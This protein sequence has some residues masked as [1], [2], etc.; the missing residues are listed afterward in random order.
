MTAFILAVIVNS[1]TTG[2]VSVR[3]YSHPEPLPWHEG[4]LASPECIKEQSYSPGHHVCRELP[5][6]FWW[7]A[8]SQP[9]EVKPPK[10]TS[11]REAVEGML[12]NAQAL[13]LACYYKFELEEFKMEIARPFLVQGQRPTRLCLVPQ[14][15]CLQ[16]NLIAI[17]LEQL[18]DPHPL[19][20]QWVAICLGRIWQNFD[21]ARWCGV[22]D[23]AH[24]KLCS[25]L[26]DPIPEVSPLCPQSYQ[27]LSV[28]TLRGNDVQRPAHT[29]KSHA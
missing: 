19:L 12:S 26:S 8:A 28:E 16:G 21:S 17:C 10:C 29:L 2:Q 18:S 22:R 13:H 24:E 9:Q 1:Y 15:A 14:E 5:F 25:L 11:S 23:S 7:S 4:D 20:R 6:Y 27:V 3:G